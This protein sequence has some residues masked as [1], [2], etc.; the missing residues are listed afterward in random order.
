MILPIL[1]LN[2]RDVIILEKEI[3]SLKKSIDYSNNYIT[4]HTDKICEIMQ[5]N[6]FIEPL[7][8]SD[9]FQLT[10]LGKIAS[11]IAEIH[12][13]ILSKFMTEWNYFENFTYKQLI[14]LFACFTDIKVPDEM[15]M[16]RP[17]I[18]DSY[19]QTKIINIE[20]QYKCY[21][22]L[23]TTYQV[24][25]GIHY[26]NALNFDII[27]LA[28]SW[29]DCETEQEC[30]TFIQKEVYSKSISIGDFTKAMLKIVTITNEF[31]NICEYI[32]SVDLLYKLNQIEK[33]VLKYVTTSQS[34]YL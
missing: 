33:H 23:E 25:T 31:V 24:D 26:E 6:G 3:D 30:K 1:V 32:H 22:D 11:N 27:E 29:C 16:I 9:G 4:D 21:R 8:T 17:K 18:D 14:G 5:K 2:I 20:E 12:P 34:L 13:L 7:E 15:R 19:L 28:M 10:N